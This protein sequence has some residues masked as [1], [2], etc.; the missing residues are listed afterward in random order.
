MA[1]GRRDRAH[2]RPSL[3]HQEAPPPVGDRRSIPHRPRPGSRRVLRPDGGRRRSRR[4]RGRRRGGA[5]DGRPL[6][7]AGPVDPLDPLACGRSLDQHPS[8]AARGRAP[9]VSGREV[10]PIGRTTHLA[11]LRDVR[12]RRGQRSPAGQLPGRP[13]TRDRTPHLADERGPLPPLGHLGSRPRVAR[14][15]RSDR[16]PRGDVRDALQARAPSGTPLQL[17]R[18]AIPCAARAAL[19]L[20][21]RQR[22]SRGPPRRDPPGLSRA[23]SPRWGAQRAGSLGDPGHSRDRAGRDPLDAR[24]SA[25]ERDRKTAARGGDPRDRGSPRLHQEPEE[26]EP[27]RRAR[28]TRGDTHRHRPGARR[29]ARSRRRR[30][31][32]VGS[33]RGADDR[34]PRTRRVGRARGPS[35]GR[36][37]LRRRCD[38]ERG[39]RADGLRVPLQPGEKAVLDRVRRPGG[40]TR[41]ELL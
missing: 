10:S 11:V 23:G 27:P 9:L 6:A 19:R 38:G 24:G 35:P 28:G 33:R 3:R 40:T 17:V 25:R 30:G 15:T 2:P 26:R 34:E 22:Q 7:R 20:D 41:P 16:A 1:H 14:D 12:R 31:P 8:G 29:R 32:R 13:E 21:R 4:W 37:T 18:H 39:L 36:A 5:A